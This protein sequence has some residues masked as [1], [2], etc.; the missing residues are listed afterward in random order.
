MDLII[1]NVRK[2]DIVSVVD[3]KVSG[4]Q[5]AYRGMISDDYLDNMDRDKYDC[6]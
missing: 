5:S 1:R 4:W 2:D 6:S 3:I